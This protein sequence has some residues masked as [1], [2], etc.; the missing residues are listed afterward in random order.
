MD[1]LR[2]EFRVSLP[3]AEAL[4]V[5]EDALAAA[6]WR[7]TGKQPLTLFGAQGGNVAWP[8]GIE[9]ALTPLGEDATVIRCTSWTRVGGYSRRRNVAAELTA[10]GRLI[11]AQ[12]PLDPAEPR[13][14]RL[15]A[16]DDGRSGGFWRRLGFRRR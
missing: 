4:R 11:A 16:L 3:A 2:L 9:L 15:P 7:I 10:L 6:R 14:E 5:C 13:V 8:I 12:T 1:R